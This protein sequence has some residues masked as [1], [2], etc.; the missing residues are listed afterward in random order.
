M[1]KKYIILVVIILI[2]AS[3]FIFNYQKK[4]NYCLDAVTYH[5]GINNGNSYYKYGKTWGGKEFETKNDALEYC[6]R[7][8]K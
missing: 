5:R 6:I 3:I 4:R 8:Q 2:V 7:N 1:N